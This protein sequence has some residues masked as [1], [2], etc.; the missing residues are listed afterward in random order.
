MAKDYY[1]TLG[2]EKNATQEQI[3]NAYRTLALKFHPDRN[4]TKEAEETFK[5]I[6]TAYAVLSDPEKRKQYD[7]YGPTGFN[8]RFSEEDIFRGFNFDDIFKNMQE[9]MYFSGGF[10]PFGG[11]FPQQE[12]QKGVNLYLSFDDI[13]KGVD[14][15]F[16]VRRV[17]V[18]P[19]CR[20]NGGEPGSTQSKCPACNG[21]G[22]RHVRQ[23]TPFGRF[24]AITT[25]DQCRGK[26]KIFDK[27]CKECEGVGRVTAVEKFRVRAEKPD[28]DTK[29]KKKF[30]AF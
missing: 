22:R 20:G 7:S 16:S 4:K 21:S 12:E 14:K 2:V 8:Q 29:Q 23:N 3:K 11:G 24:E 17:K 10:D 9:N 5:E 1:S 19:N 25:C 28:T 13:E 30:W 26:G 18:C 15:E 6:N 27:V